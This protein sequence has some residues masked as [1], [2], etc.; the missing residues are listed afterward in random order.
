[1]KNVFL[2]IKGTA[3]LDGEQGEVIEF[4][5]DGSLELS[6]GKTIIRYIEGADIGAENVASAVIV[7]SDGSVILERSGGMSTRLEIIPNR[8]NCCAYATAYG[9]MQIGVFGESVSNTIGE[10]GGVLSL[11]Y[12]LDQNLRPLSRNIVEI[13]VKEVE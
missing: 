5:T 13:T 2:K 9:E 12:T 1:M 7:N 3:S 11:A 6:E 8:R 4:A 10:N